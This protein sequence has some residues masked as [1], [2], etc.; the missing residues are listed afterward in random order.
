MS[1]WTIYW[2]TRLSFIKVFLFALVLIA[3][4]ISIGLSVAIPDTKDKSIKKL[5]KKYLRYSILSTIVTWLIFALI[6]S[7]NTVIAMYVLPKLANSAYTEK[8]IKLL[9]AKL[10]DL[11][12]VEEENK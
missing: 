10:E 2:I 1:A 5:Y 6:P 4:C 12:Q 8:Y 3:A 9:D 11:L 7:K